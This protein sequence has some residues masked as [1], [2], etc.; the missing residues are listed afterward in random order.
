MFNIN[1]LAQ[2]FSDLYGLKKKRL[3]RAMK[4]DKSDAWRTRGR[5]FEVFRP[6]HENPEPSE[7]FIP[8]YALMH[9]G[10]VLGIG[11]GNHARAEAST[12]N[13]RTRIARLLRRQR[14]PAK[15]IGRTDEGW[16]L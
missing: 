7:W 6:K 1:S 9:P 10:A 16:V 5:R 2:G 12:T 8:L 3:V 11:G 14:P 4:V 13:Q 15:E